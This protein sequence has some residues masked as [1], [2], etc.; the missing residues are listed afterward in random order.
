MKEPTVFNNI[1]LP[2]AEMAE[3]ATRASLA[4]VS[5]PY[6]LGILVLSAAYG[7][8]HPDVIAFRKR[9]NPGISGTDMKEG[10]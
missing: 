8:M 2:L 4:G 10:K 5:T 3:L 1:E 7:A 9:P 6:Y